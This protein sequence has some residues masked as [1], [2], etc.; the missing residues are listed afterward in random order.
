MSIAIT[1]P[2]A[3]KTHHAVVVSISTQPASRATRERADG[4]ADEQEH[5]RLGEGGE[6]LGLPVAVRM[7]AV[8]RA[9]CHSDREEGQQRG[10]EVRSGVE[11]LRDEPEA[12]ARKARRELDPHQRQRGADR[13][14]RDTSLRSHPRSVLRRRRRSFARRDGRASPRGENPDPDQQAARPPGSRRSSRRA[15]RPRRAQRG[16]AAGSPRASRATRRSGRGT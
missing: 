5:E 13:D 6:V 4:D 3:A 10:D 12:A 7:R 1:T 14:E 11:R 16:T 9:A 8:G 2:T 15:A